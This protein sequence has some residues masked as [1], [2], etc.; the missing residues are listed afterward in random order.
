MYTCMYTCSV[1]TLV[2]S[3]KSFLASLRNRGARVWKEVAAPQVELTT[4]VSI[5]GQLLAI[6]GVNFDD[7]LTTVV[8]MY[9]CIAAVLP[10]NQLMVVGGFTG[11]SET[12]LVEF[13]L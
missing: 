9:S 8:H 13:A 5:H 11:R 4:F 3:H 6:G 1:L 2:Q 10:N 12:D 7:T